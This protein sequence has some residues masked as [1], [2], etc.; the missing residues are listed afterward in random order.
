MLNSTSP[1]LTNVGPRMTEATKIR[2]M[3]RVEAAR[4]L[5]ITWGISRTPKTLA[6]L[7]VVGG[8]PAFRK[9]GRFPLYETDALDAWAREQ[10]SEPV[11]S[12]A[13]LRMNSRKTA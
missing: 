8:G 6:K 1:I 11:R 3:R 4:Y 13:E 2:R 10:L 9:D 7:A 5:M 12:T